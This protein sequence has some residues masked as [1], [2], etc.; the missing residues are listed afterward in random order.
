[1]TDPSSGENVKGY[2]SGFGM[3][4]TAGAGYAITRRL[5]VKI[6]VSLMGGWP[7]K[8]KSYPSQ[9]LR[10]EEV[11]DPVTGLTSIIPIYSAPVEHEIKK[12]IT[13]LNPYAGII[14]RF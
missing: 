12:T 13:T 3:A 4:L 9:L 7:G 14:Y 8:S 6:N 2:G 10:Y 1:M 5:A 11:K